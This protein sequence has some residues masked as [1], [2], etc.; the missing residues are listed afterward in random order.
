MVLQVGSQQKVVDY[1]FGAVHRTLIILEKYGYPLA[2]DHV[3][4]FHHLPQRW[5][6]SW[7][8]DWRTDRLTDWPTDCQIADTFK[9]YPLHV[10]RWN[11]LK[12]KVSLAKQ[13]VSPHV[14]E[15]GETV[16][17]VC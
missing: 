9:Q 5:V 14:Q 10:I 16:M 2:H 4:F 1:K 15:Q 3:Q 7:L 12:K 8:T 13:R 17:E 11:N 6:T